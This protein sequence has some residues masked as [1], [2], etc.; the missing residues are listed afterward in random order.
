ML[1]L[2][3][4]V[5][6]YRLCPGAS[7]ALEMELSLEEIASILCC[8]LRNATITVKKMQTHRWLHWQPGRGRGKRSSLTFF[9]RPEDL[10]FAV[11]KERVQ[12]GEIQAS[13]TI[14]ERYREEL[15]QLAD[16]YQ[17]WMNSQFGLHQSGQGQR[18]VDTLRLC[19][20]SPFPVLDPVYK[21]LYSEAHLVGHVFDCLVCYDPNQG[22]IVPRLA[23]YW[24]SDGIGQEWTFYLRKGVLFHHGRTLTAADVCFSLLR[25]REAEPRSPHRWMAKGIKEVMAVDDSTVRVRLREPN[26]LFLHYL[27]KV[28]MA[29]VPQDYTEQMGDEFRRYPV[30]SGPFRVVRNDD[31]M[32]V[33]E[34]FEAYFGERAFLDRVEIWVVPE[35]PIADGEQALGIAYASADAQESQLF[36]SSWMSTVQTEQSFQYLSFNMAKSGPLESVSFRR[37]LASILDPHA[38]IR[39]LGGSREA[40]DVLPIA[41]SDGAF[42]HRLQKES[43]YD[44]ETLHLYTYP[45]PDH[46]EDANWIQ[47]RCARFDIPVEVCFRSPRELA[48]PA[49]QREADLIL[50]SASVDERE[51]LSLVEFLYGD[52]GSLRH[53]LSSD[54]MR[55][56][57]AL[58][59]EMLQSNSAQER[60]D[61]IAGI[62]KLLWQERAFLPLYRN[63]I[64]VLSHPGLHG[65]HL[66][67]HGWVDF[68]RVFVKSPTR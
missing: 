1:L 35:L 63:R 15:P 30:G 9:Y 64:E 34:A 68:R 32:L 65:I 25:L 36:P 7:V 53:H 10:V 11:A 40:A 42:V 38:M 20:S 58:V 21:L 45:D 37:L 29:I 54:F 27:S 46:A 18:R 23:F 26:R 48:D 31:S 8:T 59:S 39:E 66:D 61:T 22:K 67:A 6:L 57:D 13:R 19:Y 43:S 4:Y 28:C 62:K 44:G 52:T 24:E 16:R 12:M 47:K 33:L 3:Q 50:D 49:K 56:L 60:A 51:E 14:V 17:R 5:R 41:A 2:D 55:K